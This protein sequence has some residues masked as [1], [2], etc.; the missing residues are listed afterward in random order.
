MSTPNF[1]SKCGNTIGSNTISHKSPLTAL[2]LCI[3]FGTLGLH[4]FYVG[5]IGTGILMLATCG[6]LGIWVLVDV[7]LI[8]SSEFKDK[9]GHKLEFTFTSSTPKKALV[10]ITSII[11]ALIV[12]VFLIIALAFYLTS[13]LVTVVNNQLAAL[14][15]TNYEKAYS[16]TSK[17]FQ[18]AVSFDKFKIFINTYPSLKNNKSIAFY[19]REFNNDKGSIEGTLY[20]NDGASTPVKYLLVRENSTWKILAIIV[21]PIDANTEMNKLESSHTSD[22]RL[23]NK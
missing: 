10:I 23:D 4:R 6:G 14:R 8:A 7:I 19:S 17:D 1:C 2:L 12:Y 5:K 3:F 20:S 21:N 22:K 18:H 16:Y 9:E 11:S 13:G 15:E